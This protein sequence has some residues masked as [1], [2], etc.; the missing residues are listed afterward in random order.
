MFDIYTIKI[1]LN[2]LGFEKQQKLFFSVTK[3]VFLDYKKWF[4]K[5]LLNF[6]FI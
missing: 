4:Y 2:N 6:I 1:I 5:K 3:N